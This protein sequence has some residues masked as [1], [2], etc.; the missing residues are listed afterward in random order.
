[1]RSRSG[2]T[3]V[4]LLVVVAI[5]A[6]LAAVLMPVL[7]RSREKAR[8]TA[9]LSNLKQLSLALEMYLADYD[10]VFLFAQMRLPPGVTVRDHYWGR[11]TGGSWDAIYLIWPNQLMPYVRGDQI[12]RCPSNPDHWIGYAWNL[13]LGYVGALA[14]FDPTRTGPLYEGVR[15]SD[16]SYPAQ[17]VAMLDHH[18]GTAY[19]AN[20]AISYSSEWY[21]AGPPGSSVSDAARLEHDAC[22][23]HHG[24]RNVLFA[25]GHA[26]WLVSPVYDDCV[27]Y[28]GQV[29][30]FYD[31]YYREHGH[32]PWPHRLLDGQTKTGP[33]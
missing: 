2:F 18:S 14:A 33:E 25:D 11:A 31:R 20:C 19:G 30:W 21:Y 16:L 13:H 8:S 15:L 9:C 10:E 1:M 22:P 6:V 24:G 3:L 7:A 27:L 12:F 4:E 28:V 23:P 32:R 5:I 29:Y 26:K 17:T